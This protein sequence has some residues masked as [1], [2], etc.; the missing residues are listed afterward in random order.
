M[1]DVVVLSELEWRALSWLIRKFRQLAL[2]S[3]LL[4]QT[5]SLQRVICLVTIVFS[6]AHTAALIGSFDCDRWLNRNS[7]A[8]GSRDVVGCFNQLVVGQRHDFIR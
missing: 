2:I 5:L 3:H 1:R 6:L 7:L 8:V 4:R